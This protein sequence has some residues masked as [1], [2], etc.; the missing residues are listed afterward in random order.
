MMGAEDWD[1][2]TGQAAQEAVGALASVVTALSDHV[3]IV[4]D[5]LYIHKTAGDWKSGIA[6]ALESGAIKFLES[7]AKVAE[8]FS[9]TVGGQTFSH[10]HS[11]GPLNIAS[12]AG[13]TWL[14]AWDDENGQPK[15][16]GIGVK[17]GED[18]Y[19][20]CNRF[21]VWAEE[22]TVN[23]IPRPNGYS[24]AEQ[25]TGE[26]WI[27]G[28]PIYRKVI[29]VGDVP[30]NSQPAFYNHGIASF[31][32]IISCKGFAGTTQT[33]PVFYTDPTLNSNFG[34]S[35]SAFGTTQIRVYTGAIVGT[36]LDVKIILEYIK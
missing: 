28:K 5:V 14:T 13:T 7:L 15:D 24:T 18:V 27:D 34:V 8:I 19:A 25:M 22:F 20:V 16:V 12:S 30:Q 23:G 31:S 3:T 9:G 2:T 29:Q 11:D 33:L 10:F 4:N 36:L 6:L 35:I 21:D 26:T 32:R 1:K 17:D